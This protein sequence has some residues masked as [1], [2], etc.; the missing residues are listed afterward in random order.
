MIP[1]VVM[2]GKSVDEFDPEFFLV[3]LGHGQPMHNVE[4]FN[5]LKHFDFP[6]ENRRE[7]ATQAEL[8]GYIQ[9]HKSDSRVTIFSDFHFLLHLMKNFDIETVLTI[10]R[11]IAEEKPVDEA[12]IELI[13]S[14]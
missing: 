3:S 9:K 4:E 5:I 10:A 6:P 8:K 7:Q 14:L 1:S 13:E 11:C 2:Q 12:C